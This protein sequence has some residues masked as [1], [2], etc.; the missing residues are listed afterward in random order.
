MGRPSLLELRAEDDGPA[1]TDENGE[2]VT[3]EVGGRVVEVAEGT[4]L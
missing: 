1:E 3:V 4:L 2:A